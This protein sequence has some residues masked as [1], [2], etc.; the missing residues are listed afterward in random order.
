MK[1]WLVL[2]ANNCDTDVYISEPFGSE[3][4][5]KQHLIES[6]QDILL[7]MEWGNIESS[8]CTDDIYSILCRDS[9]YFYGVVRSIDIK[10]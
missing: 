4:L 5:A 3:E 7:Q 10:E 9:D 2:E 1:I 8:E 6:Y